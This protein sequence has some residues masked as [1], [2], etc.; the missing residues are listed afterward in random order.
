MDATDL[1][2]IQF[3]STSI[4]HFFFVPVTIGLAF[5]MAI[6]HTKWYRS[7]EVRHERLTRFFGT[8]QSASSR[9]WSRSSSSA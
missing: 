7:G 2:R 5:L 4:S 9:V 1:A 8:S 3:A 6:L